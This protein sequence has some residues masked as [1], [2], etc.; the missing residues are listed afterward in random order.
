MAI[1]GQLFIFG[2]FR[3]KS[4]DG[5]YGYNF[6]EQSITVYG[7]LSDLMTPLDR[8]VLRPGLQLFCDSGQ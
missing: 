5:Q 2:I 8:G 1:F 6:V 7:Y 3:Q 4:D